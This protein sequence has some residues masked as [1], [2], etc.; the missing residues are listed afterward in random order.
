MKKPAITAAKARQVTPR[1][2]GIGRMDW[3]KFDA[4]SDAEVRAAAKSDP[5]N[6]P[7]TRA[8]LAKMRRVSLARQIRIE[9]GLS[10]QEF[11][12]RFGIPVGTL[13]D[14]EQHRSEPDAATIAYLKVISHNPNAVMRALKEAS[15]V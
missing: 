9:L 14:W 1:Q 12:E 3:S 11:A 5:D 7:L 15:A 8:Q 10:Q 13:R 2:I 6:Q 4:L